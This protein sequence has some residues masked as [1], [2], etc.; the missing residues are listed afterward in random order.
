MALGCFLKSE[1]TGRLFWGGGGELRGTGDD[2]G[3]DRGASSD[4][5]T[6][7]VS[8]LDV[9]GSGMSTSDSESPRRGFKDRGLCMSAFVVSSSTHATRLRLAGASSP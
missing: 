4:H 7:G 3:L 2:G 5:T 9:G 1:K 8:G 6:A